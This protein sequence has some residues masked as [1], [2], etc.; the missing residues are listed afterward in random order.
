M[1]QCTSKYVCLTESTKISNQENNMFT[2]Y[3]SAISCINIHQ[4]PIWQLC[5]SP[6][7]FWVRKWVG[8]LFSELFQK[9]GSWIRYKIRRYIY[10]C[11]W[12][13]STKY[14]ETNELLHVT[15]TGKTCKQAVK[16]PKTNI[17]KLLINKCLIMYCTEAIIEKEIVWE[18]F[19]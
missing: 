11:K 18:Y 6:Y 8:V 2:V 16:S 3:K 14:Q 17:V 4:R 1:I 7:S 13:S 5:I 10:Y 15:L 19:L 9:F 12:E